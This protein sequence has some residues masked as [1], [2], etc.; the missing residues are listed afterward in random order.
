MPT[1]SK[2]YSVSAQGPKALMWPANLTDVYDYLQID[3]FKYKPNTSG[4]LTGAQVNLNNTTPSTGAVPVG[5]LGTLPD[6]FASIAATTR[7]SATASGSPLGTVFLPVPEDVAYADNPQWNDTPVGVLGKFGPAVGAEALKGGVENSAAL[8]EKIQKLAGAGAIDMLL[9]GINA[10]GADPNAVTQNINGKIANPYVEQIFNGIGMRQFDFSWKLVPRSAKEQ[11][12]IFNMIKT[13]RKYAMPEISETRWLEVP[14]IFN[15]RW[16]SGG[17]QLVS[18]PYI[19][20]CVLKNVQVS[21]T[22][23]NVWATHLK[24]GVQDPYPVAY[25]LTLSFG[26]TEIITK[27]DVEKG[28]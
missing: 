17:K 21:Y 2:T 14:S 11:D 20:P 7:A 5:G 16:M 25:N 12:V 9:K 13:L 28:Y 1:A 23:D 26:E 8:T 22:P 15:L 6:V 4:A 10:I 3:I 27:T 24:D 19:K 18:L